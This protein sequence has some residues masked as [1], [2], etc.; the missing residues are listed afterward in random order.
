[1]LEKNKCV[2]FFLNPKVN[3]LFLITRVAGLGKVDLS[4]RNLL[5]GDHFLMFMQ[6]IDFQTL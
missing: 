1:M 2:L 6:E 4:T 3:T 5:G